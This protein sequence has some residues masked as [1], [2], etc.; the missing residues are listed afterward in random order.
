MPRPHAARRAAAIPALLLATAL[1]S[2]GSAHAQAPAAQKADTLQSPANAAA[3]WTAAQLTDGTHASGDH[4]L[5][6]DIVMALASTGTGGSTS[7]KATD[8]LAA[9]AEDYVTKGKPDQVF[10]GGVAKLHLVASIQGRDPADFGGQ[11][12]TKLLTDRLQ[13]NGRFTDKLASGDMS[14]QFTQSLAVLALHRT[15]KVPDNAAEFLA[16]SRCEDGGYP[17]SFKDDPTKCKSHTDSTGLAVQALLAA[18][19]TAD[20]KP[21]LDWLE[22]QQGKDGGFSDISFG[23]SPANSNTTA[24]DVQALAAGGRT[25]AAGKG[26]SWLRGRQLD[27]D[28]AAKDRGAVGYAEA[29]VDG[30]TLRATAQVVPALAGKSLSQIDGTDAARDL[31]PVKCGPGDG[32]TG[33]GNGGN[34]GNGGD[35]G[36]DTGG[37]DGGTTEGD[38]GG[39]GGDDPGTTGGDS[40]GDSTGGT[41]GGTSG[42]NDP[43]PQ[44]TGGDATSPKGPLASSGSSVL[45]LAG[46]AGALVLAGAAAVTVTR[47]RGTRR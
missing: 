6:A 19:R 14:N 47:L 43:A 35:S 42:G 17:L 29:K 11:N 16:K 32:D 23:Q 2:G 37:D 41:Q 21:A 34:G 13:D 24:L 28:A 45:P 39:S 26:V 9:N 33:G 18:G 30:T 10:A 15:G 1:L 4:G 46:L 36:G 7:D 5:T 20:A 22:K 12:L 3:T 27:C 25:E 31:E 40:G 44:T 8:W 38:S